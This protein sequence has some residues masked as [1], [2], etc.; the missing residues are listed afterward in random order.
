MNN[1]TDNLGLQIGKLYTLK[2]NCVVWE[3]LEDDPFPFPAKRGELVVVLSMRQSSLMPG[4][5]LVKLLRGDGG[6]VD[7]YVNS[8]FDHPYLEEPAL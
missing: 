7:M 8:T 5:V 3:H 4:S 1:I 6:A 2:T